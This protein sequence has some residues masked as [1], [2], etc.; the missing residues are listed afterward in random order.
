M[1][2]IGVCEPD[3]AAISTKM[4]IVA[5]SITSSENSEFNTLLEFNMPKQPITR[6]ITAGIN[7]IVEKFIWKFYHT[8][9]THVVNA[10]SFLLFFV[11]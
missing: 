8:Y 1:D 5:V 11:T 2:N 4:L 9:L 7:I 6:R 10:L 3:V